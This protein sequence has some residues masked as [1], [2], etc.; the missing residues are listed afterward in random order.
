L[1]KRPVDASLAWRGAP[2]AGEG[3]LLTSSQKWTFFI[4]SFGLFMVTLD[5]LVVST[6]LNVIRTDLG[7][8]LAQLEWIVNAYTLVFAVFLITGAALGDRYGRKRLFS[9]GVVIF[10]LASA[11]AALSNDATSLVVARAVQGVGGAIIMPLSLVL[12][13]EAFPSE[14]RGA[15][16]GAWSAIAGLGV[17][18]GP[19]VG[20]A[21]VDGLAWEWIFWLNVPVGLVLIPLAWSRLSESRGPYDRLDPLGL[22]LGSTGLVGIVLG[23]VRAPTHG[24]SSAEIVFELTAGT[25]LLVAFV[26]WERRASTPMLPMRFFRSRTFTL[27]QVVSLLMYFGLF[28]VVFL[29]AQ[30]LQAVQGF[31]PF[32]AGLRTLPWTGMPMVIAP[33]ASVAAE[34]F[35]GGRLMAGGLAFMAAGFAYLAA[36]LTTDISY[37]K[38]VPGL[39]AAGIGMGLYFS[40]VAHT[41]LGA[42][43]PEE[44]GQAAGAHSAVRE[45]GGVFGVAV[46]ATIFASYG[47]YETAQTFT[48]GTVPALWAG[49]AILLCGAFAALAIPRPSEAGRHADTPVAESL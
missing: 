9:S 13:S 35:G 11:G 23:L 1:K 48:D 34:R 27:T 25:V 4:V 16:L 37:L 2:G 7:A 5:N 29:M 21:V 8:S 49:A 32:E 10:T 31:S 43:R 38:M 42:V 6:A 30:F 3:T 14:R 19:L 28:G 24:W 40:P 36:V 15:V 33:F 47:G 22:L 45:I 18:I 39:I 17:A 20:G 12:V 44:A 46:L 41:I 26:V